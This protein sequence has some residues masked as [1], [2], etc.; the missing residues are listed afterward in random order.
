MRDKSLILIVDDNL[1]NIELLEAHLVPQGY[2]IIRAENGEE[3]LKQA[4]KLPDLILLDVMMPKM[5]GIE[6]LK[7]LRTD[8]KT[9]LIPVVMVTA[10]REV[11]DKVNAPGSRQ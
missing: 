10:L 9:R 8:E 5:S 7:K 1:Q 2:D 6:V 3:A 4:A 11:E